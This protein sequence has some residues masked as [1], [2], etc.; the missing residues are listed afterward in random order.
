LNPAER[1]R[2]DALLEEV[3]AALPRR[4]HDLLEESPLIVDDHPSPELIAEL[5]LDPREDNLCGLHSGAALT[6]R[7]V[8]HGH[9]S[10][11]T[12]HIFREGVIDHAGGWQAWVD[13]DGEQWGGADAVRQEIRITLLHELGHHFGLNEDDLA[14][15]GYD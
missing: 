8:V 13:A 2:F 3:I 15:L 10:P 7:S 14:D 9:E 5:G 1:E 6:E 4:I 12:I 11:E